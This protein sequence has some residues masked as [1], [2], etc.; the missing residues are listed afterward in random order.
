VQAWPTLVLIDPDGG[1]V[2]GVSGE[3][4]YDLLD[5]VIGMLVREFKSK[6]RLR[7]NSGTAAEFTLE[8]ARTAATPLW[9]PGKVF[10]DGA[11]DRIFIADSNQNRIVMATLDGDVR[12]VAGTGVSGFKDGPFDTALFA[13]RRAWPCAKTRKATNPKRCTSPTR[14]TTRSA[15]WTCAPESSRPLPARAAR[16]STPCAAASARRRRWPPRGR[17]L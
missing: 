3:G 9:Y 1:L 14:T 11:G 7:R 10:A 17:C 6:G 13:T 16:P 8:A 12:A 5:R 2:G 15:R 4:N